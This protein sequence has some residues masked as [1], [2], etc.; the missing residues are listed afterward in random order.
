[1]YV[2]WS[3]MIEVIILKMILPVVPP[4]TGA[5]APSTCFLSFLGLRYLLVGNAW[6]EIRQEVVHTDRDKK[7]TIYIIFS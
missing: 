7:S 4:L 2:L 1:M 6:V 5:I 3:L